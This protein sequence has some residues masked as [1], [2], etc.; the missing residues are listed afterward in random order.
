MLDDVTGNQFRGTR[1][2]GKLRGRVKGKTENWT[3]PYSHPLSSHPL[4]LLSFHPLTLI[5][6]SPTLWSSNPLT[7]SPFHCVILSPSHSLILSSTPLIHLSSHSLIYIPESRDF[8]QQKMNPKQCCYQQIALGYI[9]QDNTDMY[10]RTCCVRAS[11]NSTHRWFICA[12]YMVS[13]NKIWEF[14]LYLMS[15]LHEVSV[16]LLYSSVFSLTVYLFL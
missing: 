10:K 4:P 7:F 3:R 12:K 6:W 5:L 8:L 2:R 15:L 14:E 9:I 16:G 11:W 1:A 13:F